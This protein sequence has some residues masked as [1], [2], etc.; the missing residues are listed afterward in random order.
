MINPNLEIK[1]QIG[2]HTAVVG[3]TAAFRHVPVNV[4]KRHLDA[5]ALAVQTILGVYLQPRLSTLLVRHVLVNICGA[6]ASFRRAI[7]VM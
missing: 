5:A 2:S 3:T 7:L 4:L 6:E 1:L